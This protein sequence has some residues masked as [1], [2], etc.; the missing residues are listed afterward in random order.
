MKKTIAVV[1]ALVMAL[2]LV[3]CGSSA[4]NDAAGTYKLR[5]C[6]FVGTD[7]WET[8]EDF[9][10]ELNADGT[11]TRTTDGSSFELTWDIDG[12]SF[13]MTETFLAL[14]TDYTGTL[15]DGELHIYN[16]DPTDDL[17]YEYILA[18]A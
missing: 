1:L 12:E 13:T 8:D 4:R 6:K 5:Q 11:G 16:G 3:A 2:M 15:K 18:K 9:T 17:T 7:E 10:L 14:T